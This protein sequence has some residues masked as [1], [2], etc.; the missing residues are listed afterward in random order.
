M[1]LLERL[2]FACKFFVESLVLEHRT[3][4]ESRHFLSPFMEIRFQ[5]ELSVYVDWIVCSFEVCFGI[6]LNICNTVSPS[7]LD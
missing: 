2:E 5:L 1:L 4:H 3:W 7:L 6:R